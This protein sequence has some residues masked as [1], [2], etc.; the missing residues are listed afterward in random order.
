MG[1]FCFELLYADG[2]DF[3]GLS[4]LECRA[5]LMDAVTL[6]DGAFTTT[7]LEVANAPALDAAFEQAVADGSEGL[8]CKLVRAAGC[9]SSSSG[10]TALSWLTLSTSSWWAPTPDEAG[11]GYHGARGCVQPGNGALSDSRR[12]ALDSDAE[13]A[14]LLKIGAAGPGSAGRLAC[15]QICGSSLVGARGAQRRAH[16]V[17]QPHCWLELTKVG[18]RCGF[19]GSPAVGVTTD[20]TTTQQLVELYRTAH[21]ASTRQAACTR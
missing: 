18:F 9:G 20:A 7:A 2:Q 21:R 17:A 6:S 16:L 15:S 19:P 3:T 1:R 11:G 14:A 8:V 5:R 4:Y 13:L 10:I 12:A